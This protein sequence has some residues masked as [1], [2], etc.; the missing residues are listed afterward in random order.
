MR[1]GRNSNSQPYG[2]EPQSP[3]SDWGNSK[4]E[5]NSINA[6][7]NLVVGATG[8]N[9]FIF[10]YADFANAITANSNAP[11]EIFPNGVTI[12]QNANT[13]QPTQQKKWQFR[14]DF[15]WYLAARA[16]SATA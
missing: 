5:F 10:Q 6:N 2:A 4:N 8:L 9:E 14:D 15:S 12:G 16:V 1:Y 11:T 3:P 13:P 7:Y